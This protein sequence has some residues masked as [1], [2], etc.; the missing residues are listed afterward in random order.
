MIK[1]QHQQLQQQAKALQEQLGQAHQ[2][3]SGTIKQLQEAKQA[4]TRYQ[5]TCLTFSLPLLR[6]CQLEQS[7]SLPPVRCASAALLP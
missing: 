1:Q 3:E 2:E 5:V 4:L 7:C 6:C